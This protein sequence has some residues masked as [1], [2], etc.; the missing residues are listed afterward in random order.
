METKE[1]DGFA[2]RVYINIALCHDLTTYGHLAV[3]GRRLKRESCL[4]NN[5]LQ[6]KISP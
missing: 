4:D 6:L 5:M 3:V 1:W 2:V